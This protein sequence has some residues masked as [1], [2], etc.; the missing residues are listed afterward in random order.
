MVHVLS[1]PRLAR[2]GQHSSPCPG[3]L[4]RDAVIRALRRQL[5]RLQRQQGSGRNATNS[6]V[7]PSCNPLGAPKAGSPKAPSQRRRGGQPGHPPTAPAGLIPV[8]RLTE[9]PIVCIPETC[10]HCQAPLVG[11]DDWPT[12]HQVI[13]LPPLVAEVREYRR[14]TLTCRGCGQSTRGQLPAGVPEAGYGPRLQAF[15]SLCTGC[16]HLSKRQI[17]ELLTDTFNIPIALGTICNIEQRVA[18]AVAEPVAEAHRH[19]QQAAVVHA[20]ET[21]W[22]QQPHKHWLWTATTD[23]VA[24]FAV[25]DRRN[26][27]SARALLGD[28]FAGVVVSDRYKVYHWIPRRQLCWAHLRRDWQAMIDRGGPSQTLG[29]RLRDQTDD[30]FHLWHQVREGALSRPMFRS[31]TSDL[32]RDIGAGLRTGAACAHPDTAGVCAD[33]LKLEPFLWTFVD[34]DGVEPT[35]N[36]AERILRQAV[37]W[38]KKSSGTRGAKGSRYVERILTTVATCRLQA[39]N[40]MDYLTAACRA[41]LRGRRAPSLLPRPAR[42]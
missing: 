20:D 31:V 26:K 12:I 39:R 11:K 40:V 4:Q 13:E 36:A 16:Y 27:T 2:N 18:A 24:V 23:R 15:V 33:I 42:P 8:Q 10:Q 6:S 29:Q 5:Q 25:H 14:H 17:E 3:C 22:P 38:R 28:A 37:L 30:L 41:A 32:R 19:V 1:T 35:N 7:P 34:T 9:P 21:S